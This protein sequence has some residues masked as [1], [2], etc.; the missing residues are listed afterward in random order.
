[1]FENLFHNVFFFLRF[2]SHFLLENLLVLLLF[3]CVVFNLKSHRVYQN[4]FI[5]T[6]ATDVSR[7]MLTNSDYI[8]ELSFNLVLV[9]PFSLYSR[10]CNGNNNPDDLKALFTN[11]NFSAFFAQLK[12][13]L[14]ISIHLYKNNYKH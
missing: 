8:F 4:V 13:K 14:Y 12:S 7:L 10:R 9:I 5:I 1:M 2:L 11:I 6:Y 3:V